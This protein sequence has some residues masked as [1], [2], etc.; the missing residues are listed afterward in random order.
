MK[1]DTKAYKKTA[2]VKSGR[3]AHAKNKHRAKRPSRFVNFLFLL[4]AT[5]CIAYYIALGVTV[6]FGQSLMFLWPVF[7]LLFFMRFIL[8]ERT[9]RTGKP[10]PLPKFL[11]RLI[12]AGFAVFAVS[13]IVIELVIFSACFTT[14]GPGLDYIIVLGAK[15]N[16]EQPGGALRNRIQVAYE[17][18]QES[19][20][21]LIIASGGQGPDEGISEAECIRR[22]LDERGVPAESILLEDTSTSTYENIHNSMTLMQG[23]ENPRVGIVTNN[24]HIYR[25]L[26]IADA[27]G[28]AEF[29]GI[30]VYTSPI[31]FPH[32]MLREY[33]GVI[34]GW[35]TGSW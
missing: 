18:W 24:F 3:N 1:P 31:S 34:V 7:A 22:G 13:F 2:S 26:K 12:H 5:A 11:I 8:V 32:Y 17:Y 23:S 4:A 28:S 30:Y 19:P 35:L 16:G 33:F 14:T 9:I 15:V 6:R 29:Y 10:S 21:T 27:A 20:D 25:A